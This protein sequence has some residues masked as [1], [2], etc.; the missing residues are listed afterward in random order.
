MDAPAAPNLTH[1]CRNLP[2]EQRGRDQFGTPER[3]VPERRT[4]WAGPDLHTPSR[5]STRT[6]VRAATPL[7]RIAGTVRRITSAPWT[8]ARAPRR[9]TVPP[10]RS[11]RLDR[12]ACRSLRA[13]SRSSSG[14]WSR[15][16]R[17]ARSWSW[18]TFRLYT[19]NLLELNNSC[20]RRR[21]VQPSVSG[22]CRDP[23]KGGS[24]RLRGSWSH[25]S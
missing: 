8:A 10:G 7:P 19:A 3:H 16:R 13:D 18:P 4:L 5:D 20:S 14:S 6:I 1:Q 22:R 17:P 23:S 21:S 15:G 12:I 9:R 24:L 11:S 25:C 2:H